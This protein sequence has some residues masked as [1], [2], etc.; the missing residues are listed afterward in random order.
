MSQFVKI[1]GGGGVFLFD[2]MDAADENLLL[3]VNAALANGF[4]ANPATGEL[5][6]QHPDFIPVAG[7]NTL[8]LGSGRDYNARNRLDAATLDRWNAGRVQIALDPRIEESMFWS[9]INREA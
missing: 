4:F 3:G 8:G 5:I 6:E 9:I 2:E 7:M 1:Y